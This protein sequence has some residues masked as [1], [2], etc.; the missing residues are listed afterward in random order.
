[1]EELFKHFKSLHQT[2]VK[3]EF[4]TSAFNKMEI[5]SVNY[6]SPKVFLLFIV[7]SVNKTF[8]RHYKIEK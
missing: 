2:P 1:M 5:F 4:D 3:N 6:R 8:L 7:L